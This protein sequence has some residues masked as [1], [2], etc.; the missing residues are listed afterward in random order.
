MLGGMPKNQSDKERCVA[1][2]IKDLLRAAASASHAAGMLRH[3]LV[4]RA[5]ASID[6]GPADLPTA[7]PSIVNVSLAVEL[8]LKAFQQLDNGSFLKSHLLDCLFDDLSE[9]RAVKV[10]EAYRRVAS[11][12]PFARAFRAGVRPQWD[13]Q[14]SRDGWTV[15]SR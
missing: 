2:D 8:W 12:S 7:I 13:T 6:G 11:N 4:A 9:G 15:L 1:R 5:I 10:E 14:R 3:A